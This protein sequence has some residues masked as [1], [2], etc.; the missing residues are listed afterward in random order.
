M[1]A[2]LVPRQVAASLDDLLAGASERGRWAKNADSLSGSLFEYAVLDGRRYVVKHIGYDLDWLMRALGDGASG[3]AP[4]ALVMWR[5]GL[6]DALPDCIDHLTAGMAWDPLTCRLSVLMRDASAAF[7]PTSGVIPVD[8]QHRFLDHMARM[9]AR[10]WEF[11]DGYGLLDPAARYQ[12]LTP[13]MSAREAAAGHDDPVPRAV[14][15][16]WAGLRTAAPDAY[17]VATA[18]AADPAPLLRALDETPA[19]LVHGDWKAGNL[20]SQPDGR[21]VLVDWGWPGRAGPC[22]DLAWYLAVNCDLLPES[23]EATADRLRGCLERQDIATAGWWPRQLE[24]ALVGAFVQLGWSKTG[25]PAELA[26]WVDRIVPVAR[27]LLR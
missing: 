21:T 27:D 7:L 10:F 13:A 22:V 25:D 4:F 12:A 8:R 20:G 26:W 9:H 18:L 14:P 3:T 6:L 23:K 15:A 1:P 11:A 5:T 24:L 17:E 16:G 2:P 19:T